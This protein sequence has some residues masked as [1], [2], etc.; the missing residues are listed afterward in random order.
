M[1]TVTQTQLA[2]P[3][4]SGGLVPYRLSVDQYEAMIRAGVFTKRDRLELIEGL[5]VAKMTKG[6]M[7]ST[8][9]RSAAERSSESSHPSGTSGR[10][11]LYGSRAGQRTG[12]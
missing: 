11:S 1:S 6:T 8:A 2:L 7:H 3:I 12:A 5:L 4:L 10:R 9:R